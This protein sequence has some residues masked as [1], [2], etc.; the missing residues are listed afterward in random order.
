MRSRQVANGPRDGDNAPAEKARGASL[1][2][3]DAG[4]CAAPAPK[5]PAPPSPAARVPEQEEARG[6]VTARTQSETL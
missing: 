4:V 5:P 6:G 2:L 1:A 3:A